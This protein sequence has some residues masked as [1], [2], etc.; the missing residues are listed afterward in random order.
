MKHLWSMWKS[1]LE[2][3]WFSAYYSPLLFFLS[4]CFIVLIRDTMTGCE[5]RW[6]SQMM[7]NVIMSTWLQ[8]KMSRY[9]GNPLFVWPICEN[10]PTSFGWNIFLSWSSLQLTKQIQIKFLFHM[11]CHLILCCQSIQAIKCERVALF[12][13]MTF[14]VPIVLFKHTSAHSHLH[15]FIS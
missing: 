9:H 2:N 15:Y 13:V 3:E 10:D 4:K 8:A 1:E 5:N 7:L 12:A 6:C 11:Q 14:W